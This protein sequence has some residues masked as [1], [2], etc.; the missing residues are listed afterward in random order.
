MSDIDGP[1]FVLIL[2]ALEKYSY[3]IPPD[4]LATLRD[5]ATLKIFESTKPLSLLAMYICMPD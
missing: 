3:I 4:Q 2:K 5:P 1:T